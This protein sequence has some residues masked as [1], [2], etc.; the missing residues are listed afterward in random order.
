[1]LMYVGAILTVISTMIGFA[2]LGD[3]EDV[4][5]DELR[6]EQPELTDDE[7]E[8]TVDIAM[9]A[10]YGAMFL[11]LAFAGVWVWM[12]VMN[13]RGRSWARIMAAI[14][15]GLNIAL[16]LLGLLMGAAGG[17]Q[18]GMDTEELESPIS[19]MLGIAQAGLAAVILILLFQSASSAYYNA[20]S[21]QRSSARWG[22]GPSRLN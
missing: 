8:T 19:T 6:D 3:A 1:M 2:Q 12:A 21:H 14:L 4:L 5:R 17:L 20:V 10:M 22:Y 7:L 16:T 13:S 11:G 9:A 18:Q 15:G